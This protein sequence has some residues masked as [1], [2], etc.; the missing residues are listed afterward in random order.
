MFQ[1]KTAL[2]TGAS[3][4]LG[5]ALALRFA[6]GGANLGLFALDEEGLQ[7]VAA[8]CRERGARVLTA[9]G[10]VG[11]A[12]D[13][14]RWVTD[15]ASEFGSVDC[16]IACAGVSMW[17][18]FD[19]VKDLSLFRKLM[20]TNYLGT[21]HCVYHALPH[22]KATQGMIVA[23]TS[24]QGRIGVPLH[25]GYVASKHALEGFFAALRAELKGSGV[26]ILTV[27]PHWLRGTNLRKQ[28]FGTDGAALGGSSRGHSKESIS[29][30]E[31]CEAIIV[32]MERRKRDLVIPWKLRLLPWLNLIHPSIVEALVSG[33]V[34]EQGR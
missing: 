17:A 4:G 13:C 31:C 11:R 25:T 22:L 27:L 23:I 16:L 29:L 10:D 7:A 8:G 3:S 18:R 32:A 5:A 26:H 14:E 15:A 34:D 21:V 30:E 2:I 24:I 28:A 20:E 12:E 1:N 9:A 19:E 6:E 33:K